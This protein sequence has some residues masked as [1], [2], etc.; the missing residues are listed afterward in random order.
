MEATSDVQGSGWLLGSAT[1][2]SPKKAYGR[3]RYSP[4]AAFVT[5]TTERRNHRRR[6]D[7]PTLC[8]AR[9]L[10]G[11]G[12]SVTERIF[13]VEYIRIREHEATRGRPRRFPGMKTR[14]APPLAMFEPIQPDR[15]SDSRGRSCRDRMW[16][17]PA[18]AVHSC[19][20]RLP[21][22]VPDLPPS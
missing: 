15:Y 4:L 14:S 11:Q 6:G 2:K 1:K 20:R 22:S 16:P 7:T 18:V 19:R 9:E 3:S 17:S 21:G 12:R 5:F 8:F 13:V 10:V